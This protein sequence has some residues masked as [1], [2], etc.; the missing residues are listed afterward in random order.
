MPDHFE[1][2]LAVAPALAAAAQATTTLRLGALVYGNDYRHPVVLA[3]DM[4]TLDVLSNGRMEFGIGAG[5]MRSD[6][7]K[8]G[9]EYDRPGIRI[10]RMQ[11][12]LEIIRGLFADGPV[13]FDGEHYKITDMEGWP[14]PV[15]S[16]PPIHIGGGGKRMLGIAAQEADIIGI[17]ANLRAG[18]VGRDAT[19]DVTPE[20][21]DE[22]VDWIR[23]AAGDRIDDIELS[24]LVFNTQVT[25][26]K[27]N[28]V[29]G[30]A[31]LFGFT[32]EQVTQ[33]PMLLIGS[34]EEIADSLRER[35][36]RWGINY[37]I[38]QGDAIDTLTPVVAELTGT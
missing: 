13:N 1:D 9:M 15:Q 32:S 21:F 27:E 16:P 4:A 17:T 6:Y 14:K 8:A 20:K 2:Q 30:I 38:V 7:D 19:N 31:E 11:E 35:R 25:D 33:T 22:K 18:V 5:W 34:P 37:I 29:A 12:S 36:E 3:K 23:A 26:D 24:V 28:A 10:E